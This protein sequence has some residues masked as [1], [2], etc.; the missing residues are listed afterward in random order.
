MTSPPEVPFESSLPFDARRAST[1]VVYCSDGRFGDAMEEFLFEAL[2]LDRYDRLVVP[3][4]PGCLAGHPQVWRDEEIASGMLRFL[5]DA[6]H[7]ER[8]VLVS[9]EDCGFYAQRLGVSRG[10]MEP[11]QLEDLRKAAVRIRAFAHGLVVETYYARCATGKVRVE[12]V[13]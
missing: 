3:G 8:I 10:E 2:E 1:G 11:L 6:H 13:D 12:R 5:H 4:G 9:H 7:L